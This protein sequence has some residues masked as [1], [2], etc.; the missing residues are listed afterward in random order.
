VSEGRIISRRGNATGKLK[1]TPRSRRKYQP[2][3]HLLHRNVE[4]FF[5]VAKASLKS[6]IHLP[7]AHLT[8]QYELLTALSATDLYKIAIPQTSFPL[9]PQN[10]HVHPL[11]S[12]LFS[13]DE[14]SP[15]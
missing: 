15:I 10:R 2:G 4:V 1:R 9:L 13:F 11:L 3:L 8:F 7:L 14:T 12:T 5:V 6:R